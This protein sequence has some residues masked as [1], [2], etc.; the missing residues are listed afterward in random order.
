MKKL[1]L[2]PVVCLLSFSCNHTHQKNNKS[3]QLQQQ[4]ADWLITTKIKVAIITDTSIAITARFVSVTTTNGVVTLTG[5]VS[6]RAD[7]EKIDAIAKGVQGVKR[8][9]NKIIISKN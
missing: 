4:S 9:H 8:V 7:K 1:L 6:Q 3:V 2:I 5:S